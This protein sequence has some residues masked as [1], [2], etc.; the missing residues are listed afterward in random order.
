MDDQRRLLLLAEQM[1]RLDAD[2]GNESAQVWFTTA[3][4]SL[5]HALIDLSDG[6]SHATRAGTAPRSTSP[7][8]HGD[9]TRDRA[10]CSAARAELATARL[11]LTRI[12]S[13]QDGAWSDLG[14]RTTGSL[15]LLIAALGESAARAGHDACGPPPSTHRKLHAAFRLLQPPA[16]TLLS[17]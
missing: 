15:D 13:A 16:A 5:A 11:T 6:R 3:I 7:T 14:E 1:A 2:L 4:N 8:G 10:S 12:Q 17:S 9:H